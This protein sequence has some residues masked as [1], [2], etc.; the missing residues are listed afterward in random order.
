MHYCF[1]LDMGISPAVKS[2]FEKF[3]FQVVHAQDEKMHDSSDEDIVQIAREKGF[4][5]ITTDL[6]FSK[7]VVLQKLP[8]PTIITLRLRNPSADEQTAVLAKF[9]SSISP[10]YLESCLVT[11]E[12][13]RHRR[14]SLIY[15]SVDC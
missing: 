3:G 7:I 1:F 5:I 2:L 8:N 9:F 12:K 15:E 11:I 4:T 10:H 13:E 6:D 14:R